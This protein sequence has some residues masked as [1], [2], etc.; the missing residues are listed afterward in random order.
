MSVAGIPSFLEE[1]AVFMREYVAKFDT[2]RQIITDLFFPGRR[3]NGLY[4]PGAYVIANSLVNI[5]FLF[6]CAVLFAVIW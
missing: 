1:R 5:P 3:N 4:G 6:L 2:L